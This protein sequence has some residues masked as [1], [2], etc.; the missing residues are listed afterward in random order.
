M[1]TGIAPTKVG[2]ITAVCLCQHHRVQV[3]KSGSGND[4][5]RGQES[6]RKSGTGRPRDAKTGNRGFAQ[7]P[8]KG[9][10]AG[11]KGSVHSH[12]EQVECFETMRAPGSYRWE[13]YY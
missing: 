4:P 3:G 6:D 11:R 9:S 1:G 13:A 2:V 5:W 8:Q 12:D 7:D 10:K